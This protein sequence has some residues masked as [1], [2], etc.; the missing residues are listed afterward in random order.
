LSGISQVAL[1]VKG[2]GLEPAAD[3][4]TTRPVVAG[5]PMAKK[6]KE[7]KNEPTDNGSAE[8]DNSQ[9][10]VV[11]DVKLEVVKAPTLEQLESAAEAALTSF[12]ESLWAFAVAVTAIH[13]SGL[14]DYAN[15]ARGLLPLHGATLGY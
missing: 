1:H 3:S 9:S 11:Q 5:K 10:T 14:Y 7:P 13:D 4:E 12:R 15:E 6:A 8:T 2:G